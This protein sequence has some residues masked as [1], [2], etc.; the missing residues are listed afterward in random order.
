M[1]KSKANIGKS[2]QGEQDNKNIGAPDVTT[3]LQCEL[4]KQAD[5]IVDLRSQIERGSQETETGRNKYYQLSN[6]LA[7]KDVDY[8]ELKRENEVASKRIVQ[9]STEVSVKLNELAGYKQINEELREKLAEKGSEVEKLRRNECELNKKLS[10]LHEIAEDNG[11]H[12]EYTSGKMDVSK[13]SPGDAV[14]KEMSQ[15][16][17]KLD[18]SNRNNSIL[19]DQVEEMTKKL[20]NV[21]NFYKKII[22]EK[23][24]AI[25]EYSCITEDDNDMKCKLKR[26]LIKFRS[27]NELKLIR[28]LKSTVSNEA[29]VNGLKQNDLPPLEES[30]DERDGDTAHNN[31]STSRRGEDDEGTSRK[32]LCRDGR[33]CVNKVT[34]QFRHELVNKP[35]RFGFKCKKEAKCLF[36]HGDEGNQHST[37][38]G[39]MNLN[40]G[41]EKPFLGVTEYGAI[42]QR[43]W[44][45][46]DRVAEGF[47]TNHISFPV[48]NN[49]KGIEN[50]HFNM[51]INNPK[52][53]L[54]VRGTTCSTM[55]TTCEFNHTPIN[56]PCRNGSNCPN[57]KT[58]CLFTH[59]AAESMASLNNNSMA[60]LNNNRRGQF[61]YQYPDSKNHIDRTWLRAKN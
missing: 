30:E 20:D 15:L 41:I 19:T 61:N 14:S 45:T 42:D 47:P 24:V 25:Q 35:C 10:V 12:S 44:S 48:M 1:R 56:K 29:E 51:N 23:D 4:L 28:E 39:N 13:T 36:L 17:C 38:T 9:L 34:C 22:D 7:K 32:G 46:N 27:E 8:Q 33:Q 21:D 2:I 60:S 50:H 49:R 31:N 57:R 16:K 26:L 53:G 40:G 18:E 59:N 3:T 58:T 43:F 55:H 6:E 11:S 54:C 37:V 52:K 5:V